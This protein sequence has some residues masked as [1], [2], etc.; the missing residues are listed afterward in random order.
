MV[1][2]KVTFVDG[3]QF[4]GEAASGHAIVMDGDID[5]G[6]KDTGLRP[7]EVLLIG[8]G[9]CSGMDVVSIL[10]KKKQDIRG[11]T[12]N[13]KGEKADSYPK[14]FT[15]IDIEFVVA[16]RNLSEEAVKRAVDLS[17]GKYCSVKATLEGSAKVDFSYRIIQE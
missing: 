13:V 11:L 4:V 17:M 14:R 9:G 12:I 6:G 2:A 3:L 16:G 5:S 8:L 7:M 1:E 15:H 10:K